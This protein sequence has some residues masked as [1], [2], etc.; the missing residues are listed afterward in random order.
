M[1][2]IN[3]LGGFIAFPLIYSI[4][5]SVN[6]FHEAL[7]HCQI[8]DA[9]IR[10]GVRQSHAAGNNLAAIVLVDKACAGKFCVE[11]VTENFGKSTLVVIV[12]IGAWTENKSIFER[13]AAGELK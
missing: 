8:D 11:S 10:V 12:P 6:G 4:V 13:R 3:I 9:H 7:V 5:D 2:I 1:S